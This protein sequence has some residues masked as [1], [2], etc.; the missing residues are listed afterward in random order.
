MA[1]RKWI[2][3]RIAYLLDRLPGQCWADL[4][5]WV[6]DSGEFRRRNPWSPITPTC[7]SDRDHNG[8]CYCGKLRR[9]APRE[10]WLTDE[11][12]AI[13]DDREDA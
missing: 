9:S 12:A 4:V 10:T 6:L 8:C 7:W 2:R 1:V 5:S 13:L 11:Y 3:W